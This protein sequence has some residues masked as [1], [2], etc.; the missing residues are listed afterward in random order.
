MHGGA[1]EMLV[2]RLPRRCRS[3]G[4]PPRRR[5]GAAYTARGPGASSAVQL[6]DAR[7][8]RPD[9]GRADVQRSVVT[10]VYDLL[11][12]M[13]GATRTTAIP[14]RAGSPRRLRH[15]AGHRQPP[16]GSDLSVAALAVRH[17][18]TERSVRHEC[19]CWRHHVHRIRAGAPPCAPHRLLGDRADTATR[20]AVVRL[21]VRDLSYFNRVFRRRYGAAPS[22][23]RA[24]VRRDASPSSRHDH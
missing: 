1:R 7:L 21:R 16:G 12:L 11:A 5:L 9:A 14:R 15:Q 17:R 18:C 8:G 10:H 22:E 24:Q 2:L 4:R 6:S 13:M 20:S 3:A 23:V 19:S